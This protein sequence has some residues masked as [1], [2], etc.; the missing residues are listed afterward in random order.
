ML[1]AAGGSLLDAQDLLGHS[2]TAIT[3]RVYAHLLPGGQEKSARA[4]DHLLG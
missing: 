4:L 1:I 2:S 3:E